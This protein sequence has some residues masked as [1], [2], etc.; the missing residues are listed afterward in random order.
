M[1]SKLLSLC[2]FTPEEL[3]C[4]RSRIDKA[5]EIWGLGTTDVRQAE[6]R[7]EKYFDMTIDEIR[8]DHYL[9]KSILKNYDLYL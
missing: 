6:N 8:N 9:V 4:E 5:F 2:G 1:Y 7:I 3:A